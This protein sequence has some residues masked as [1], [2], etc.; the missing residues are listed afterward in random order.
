M[1]GMWLVKRRELNG[2][3]VVARRE[4]WRSA[5]NESERLNIE[6]QSDQYYVEQYNSKEQQR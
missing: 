1:N 3:R 5:R 6:Y 2:S 4:T